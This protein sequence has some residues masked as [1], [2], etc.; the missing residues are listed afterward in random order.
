MKTFT[1]VIEDSSANVIGCS[2]A[3]GDVMLDE[4]DVLP[5][6]ALAAAAQSLAA[7]YGITIPAGIL[8]QPVVPPG[9]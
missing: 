7:K 9:N 1:S 3:E 4:A 5:R 6:S 8:P 2:T